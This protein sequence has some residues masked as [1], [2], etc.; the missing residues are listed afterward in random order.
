MIAAAAAPPIA[1]PT[2]GCFV[3]VDELWSAAKEAVL[4]GVVEAPNFVFVVM[5]DE[6]REMVAVLADN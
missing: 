3:F 1:P 5:A 6:V 2:T 4:V